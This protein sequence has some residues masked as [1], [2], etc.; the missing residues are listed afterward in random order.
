MRKFVM[1]ALVM[2]PMMIHAQANS[3]AQPKASTTLESR[4]VSPAAISSSADRGNLSTAP[5]RVST[6]VTA[7]KL[8][9]AV[10]VAASSD[11]WAWHVAGINRTSVV[12]MIVDTNGTPSNL[13][14]EQSLGSEMDKNVLAAVSQY[15]FQPGSLNNQPT[16]V[17]V[18][19]E[20]VIQ[21]TAR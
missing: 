8:I 14:I 6:G 7:P 4:L 19:L 12:S 15:R 5:L 20:I 18:Q 9:H 13:K 21:N 1:A 17:P 3:P 10:D 16:A 11:N 2:S